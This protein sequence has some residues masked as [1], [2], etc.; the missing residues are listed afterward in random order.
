MIDQFQK[1][2]RVHESTVRAAA[3]APTRRRGRG[4][5]R[6]KVDGPVHTTRVDREVWDRVLTLA[7]GDPRRIV[8]ISA[9]ECRV[10]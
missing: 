9:T 3:T 1:T 5:G 4:P 10:R 6:P 2:V 7:G 8:I